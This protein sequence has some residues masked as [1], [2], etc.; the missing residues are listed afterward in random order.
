M[1]SGKS[2]TASNGLAPLFI[3]F[4]SLELLIV[5]AADLL[6]KLGADKWVL[7][8]AN[9][10]LFCT[11]ALASLLMRASMKG[12]GGQA[13][14]KSLYG[15]FLIRFMGIALAACIYIF[16][17]RKQVNIPGLVGGAFFYILYWIIEIRMLRVKLKSP[18]VN[19]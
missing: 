2:T 4:G 19:A 7:H 15:G 13:V 6:L 9:T 1:M 12:S 17:N 3:L 14:L 18:A 11:A 10:V 8:G 16:L 5:V